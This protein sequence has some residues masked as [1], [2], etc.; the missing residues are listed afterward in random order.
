MKGNSELHPAVMEVSNLPFRILFVLACLNEDYAEAELRLLA[1]YLSPSEYRL[2]VIVCFEKEDKLCGG[3]PSLEL[4]GIDV[5]HEPYKLS[6]DQTVTY[7]S[8]KLI[9]YDI[10]VSCQNVADIYPAL[11][12]LQWRPPFIEFVDNYFEVRTDP[13][14]YTSCYVTKS[15]SAQN[16]IFANQFRVD[17]Q[18]IEISSA[19]E[20]E[21]IA[22]WT[23]VFRRVLSHRS[24]AKAPSVFTSFMQGGFECSTHKRADGRRLD[25]IAATHHD[26]HVI[27]DYNQLRSHGICTVRDGLRWHLI[28]PHPGHFDDSSF[29]PMLKAARSS[30]TQVV[31]DLMHYGWPDDLDIWSSGFVNRFAKYAAHIARVVKAETDEIPFYCPI[32][33]ISFLAWG[34]GDVAYLNPFGRER[35]FELKVQLARAAIAAMHEILA[36]DP[37][38]RFMHCEPVIN[39]VA[40]ASSIGQRLEAEQARQAQFQAFDMISGALW[41]QLGGEPRLLDITGINY[42]QQNQWVLGGSTIDRHDTRYRPF[43]SLL[44]EVYARYARPVV[45]SE[46]GTEGDG[47]VAWLKTIGCEVVAARKAGV[48][49]EGLCLY[50]IIDHVG[51]DDDRNCPSGFMGNFFENGKR[52]EYGPLVDVIAEIVKKVRDEQV[53]FY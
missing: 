3:H 46:T 17:P 39:I 41:P 11:E 33:E 14:H 2:D 1:H 23:S 43:R 49:V 26:T 8:H 7:L 5:D 27:A 21:M 19:P 34:G 35:S 37:R 32:N 9:G 20:I 24:P 31:W 29:L 50:P 45:V 38:A 12:R 22:A 51:W 44:A 15:G 25:L 30:G 6:F 52:V 42:Y 53:L 13:K 18:I 4:L 48:P 40:N 16:I 47:R 10:V 36:I 28:E